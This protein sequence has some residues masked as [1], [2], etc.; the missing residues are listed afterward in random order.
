MDRKESRHES[1]YGMTLGEEKK[2]RGQ[3][4]SADI[5]QDWSS[6]AELVSS[7]KRQAP[8]GLRGLNNLGNTCFIS[9]V[10]QVCEMIDC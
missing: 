5:E 10:L 8:L 9:S 6:N 1:V 4:N 3:K 2:Q 7:G